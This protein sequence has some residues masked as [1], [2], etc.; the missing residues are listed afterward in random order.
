MK[1]YTVILQKVAT[2]QIATHYYDNEWVNDFYWSEGNMACDC[3]REIEFA[4]ALGNNYDSNKI[5]CLPEGRFKVA[6]ISDSGE[7]L[8]SEFPINFTRRKKRG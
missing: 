8:Y 6:V 1:G 4:R 5:N 7:M 2:G 3:N